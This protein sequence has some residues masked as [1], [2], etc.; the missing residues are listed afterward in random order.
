MVMKVMSADL[1]TFVPSLVLVRA[2]HQGGCSGM[3]TSRPLNLDTW[4][5]GDKQLAVSS[6]SQ[7]AGKKAIYAMTRQY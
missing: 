1:S 2:W 3:Q 6:A 7:A 5:C 4:R